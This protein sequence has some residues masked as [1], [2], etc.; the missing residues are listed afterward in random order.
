MLIFKRGSLMSDYIK[1]L[2]QYA[3]LITASIAIFLFILKEI[4]EYLR[5]RKTKK[6]EM[7][8]LKILINNE[9]SSNRTYLKSMIKFFNAVITNKIMTYNYS[10]ITH[11]SFIEYDD[12]SGSIDLVPLIHHSVSIIDRYLFDIAK[13]NNEMMINVINVRMCINYFNS[14]LIDGLDNLMQTK[15]PISTIREY[16]EPNTN[17]INDYCIYHNKLAKYT[18]TDVD[19]LNSITI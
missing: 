17:L 6:N 10:N 11:K 13:I 14:M 15:P 4:L 9:I 18:Y 5:K 3:A 2:P 1:Y 12:G 16:L 7:K 19:D 8:A